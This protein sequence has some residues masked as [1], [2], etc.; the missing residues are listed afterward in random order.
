MLVV[1]VIVFHLPMDQM[2]ETLKSKEV[3]LFFYKVVVDLVAHLIWHHRPM[4]LVVEGD[5]LVVRKEMVEELV[6]VEKV[7]GNKVAAAVAVL[8][9][10]VVMVVHQ[11]MLDIVTIA[12]LMDLVVVAAVAAPDKAQEDLVHQVVESVF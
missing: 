10:I 1:L 7:L 6:V 8:L 12:D 5:L 3:L 9:V 2:E 11:D 4:E